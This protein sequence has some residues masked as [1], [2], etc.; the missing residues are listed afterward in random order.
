MEKGIPENFR[1]VRLEVLDKEALISLVKHPRNASFFSSVSNEQLTG[2]SREDI[3]N[4]IAKQ[5]NAYMGNNLV[6]DYR[7]A[8][9]SQ[10]YAQ[11]AKAVTA[12]GQN[13]NKWKPLGGQVEH[14]NK[15]YRGLTDPLNNSRFVID[16]SQT[17]AGKTISTIILAMRLRCRFLQIVCPNAV[18]SDWRK[19][20]DGI[21][22]FEY[23][24]SSYASIIGTNSKVSTGFSKYNDG[25]KTLADNTWLKVTVSDVGRVRKKREYEW[26]LPDRMGNA[27]YNLVGGCFVVWD[28]IQSVKN[29]GSSYG[30]GSFAGD[31]FIRFIQYLRNTHG[32]YIRSIGLSATALEKSDDLKYIMYATGQ[33]ANRTDAGNY[34]SNT[35]YPLF[36]EIIGPDRWEPWMDDIG[37]D[38]V[39]PLATRYMLINR[40]RFSVIVPEKSRFPNRTTWEGLDVK[41]A[42]LEKYKK[43]NSMLRAEAL[44]VIDQGGGTFG[45]I[46]RAITQLEEI[47]LTPIY[48][49]VVN[50]LEQDFGEGIA[51]KVVLSFNRVASV[52]QMAWR[53]EGYFSYLEAV[54]SEAWKTNANNYRATLLLAMVDEILKEIATTVATDNERKRQGQFRELRSLFKR[55]T[56]QDLYDMVRRGDLITLFSE[57]IK[58]T[59]YLGFR[60]F[61]HVAILMGNFGHPKNELSDPTKYD[62]GFTSVVTKS[63]LLKP[64]DKL[65][66]MEE[67]NYYPGKDFVRENPN[68]PEKRVIITTIQSSAVGI[69]LHD[70]SPGGVRPRFHVTS[71]PRNAR[72]L[73]QV[74]GRT[75]RSGQTSNTVR[76]VVYI[77]N[78]RGIASME[79]ILLSDIKTK[80][81][82]ILAFQK[83]KINPE[84]LR[85]ITD[86]TVRL[87]A[88]AVKQI[89]TGRVGRLDSNFGEVKDGESS[90]PAGGTNYLKQQFSEK[91]KAKAPGLPKL[92][93][94]GQTSQLT[95]VAPARP[96]R[97]AQPA[98]PFGAT[99][100]PARPAQPFGATIQ[101]ARP[102]QPAPRQGANLGLGDTGPQQQANMIARQADQSF[103]PVVKNTTAYDVIIGPQYVLFKFG[104]LADGAD[105]MANMIES[106]KRMY[107]PQRYYE[108]DA[109][110]N[111]VIL[112]T[113]TSDG[114]Y[115]SN[116]IVELSSAG[117]LKPVFK[118]STSPVANPTAIKPLGNK[119][120]TI[121]VDPLPSL[122]ITQAYRYISYIPSD[123]MKRLTISDVPNYDTSKKIS[124]TIADIILAYFSLRTV[125]NRRNFVSGEIIWPKVADPT[126]YFKRL[127][128]NFPGLASSGSKLYI[129]GPAPIIAAFPAIMSVNKTMRGLLETESL[130]SRLF[131]SYTV[132]GTEGFLEYNKRYEETIPFA[133]GFDGQFREVN[134][135]QEAERLASEPK[136]EPPPVVKKA[137]VSISDDRVT[138]APIGR[139]NIESLRE[140]LGDIM[141][142]TRIEQVMNELN[143]IGTE[144]NNS[145]RMRRLIKIAAGIQHIAIAN[146]VS[147][148]SPVNVNVS[149]ALVRYIPYSGNLSTTGYI[150]AESS[151]IDMINKFFNNALTLVPTPNI[152]SLPSEYGYYLPTPSQFSMVSPYIFM[153]IN[154][155][156]FTLYDE[157]SAVIENTSVQELEGFVSNFQVGVIQSGSNIRVDIFEKE[158]EEIVPSYEGII[159]L[160]LFAKSKFG[161]EMLF[162]PIY[163]DVYNVRVAGNNLWCDDGIVVSMIK[164]KHLLATDVTSTKQ[165][166]EISRHTLSPTGVAKVLKVFGDG[167]ASQKFT[168]RPGNKFEFVTARPNGVREITNVIRL[169]KTM[170]VVETTETSVT[171]QAANIF[172]IMSIYFLIKVRFGALLSSELTIGS[173]YIGAEALQDIGEATD[174][175]ELKIVDAAGRM[176]IG[177]GNQN[178]LN[179]FVTGLPDQTRQYVKRVEGFPNVLAFSPPSFPMASYMID[180]FQNE[181]EEEWEESYDTDFE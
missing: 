84:I 170:R 32:K 87:T 41:E 122:Y 67:F 27:N 42:D 56:K 131:L 134:L 26:N 12:I 39:A 59:V 47:K 156:R 58:W 21:G 116:K 112:K 78:L 147:P 141:Q 127:K 128:D 145:N 33:I 180:N 11:L 96:A 126:N 36:K 121:V 181:E 106:L 101:P 20:L 9:S 31:C 119:P 57:H 50:Y 89:G 49:L 132:K 69:N 137:S 68:A 46:A 120:P 64:A 178:S 169:F 70:T 71:P 35:L 94:A 175:G 43:Y 2:A 163:S 177:F 62:K 13:P 63:G 173:E 97:P 136:A 164:Y 135:D 15:L 125:I 72:T 155:K 148:S 93:P 5:P 86:D 76:H 65:Y 29:I 37:K 144:T 7:Q 10:Q 172:D 165:I 60:M 8:I 53:I 1:R 140:L 66:A 54:S 40:D 18:I 123:L 82:Q 109:S 162:H 28:E 77:K 23:R 92:A 100:Q 38:Y 151:Y 117:G 107:V 159:D 4:M 152:Q 143:I 52:R 124:G 95:A 83:G 88:E 45:L 55:H 73:I 129:R 138:F 108:T 14:I 111:L 142:N 139:V 158:G 98:Q 16:G 133:L 19:A 154:G 157:G 6:S 171:V 80:V 103:K 75:V 30:Q 114:G 113:L 115:G 167:T 91:R 44:K 160:F 150:V 149:K 3:I 61:N 104:M 153:G 161:E 166:G 51:G 74:L 105:R 85:A 118:T 146:N 17:G 110:G 102:V 81:N 168:V 179:S 48:E 79:A 99:I 25:S 130:S 174:F 176:T 22:M 24:I 90:K 34:I